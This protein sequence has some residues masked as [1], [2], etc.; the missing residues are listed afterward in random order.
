M[1]AP[2]SGPP[3]VQWNTPAGEALQALAANASADPSYN[4]LIVFGS[5]ALQMTVLP[6]LLSADIDVSL[7]LFSHLRNLYRRLLP[8]NCY[9]VRR[10]QRAIVTAAAIWRR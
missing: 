7:I 5:G 9:A 3:T 1:P 10:K 6:E 2:L 8:R 4:R